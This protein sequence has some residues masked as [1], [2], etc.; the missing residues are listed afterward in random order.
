M[1]ILN[2]ILA[3]IWLILA[4]IHSLNNNDVGFIIMY[5][6]FS[7]IHLIMGMTILIKDE[8]KNLKL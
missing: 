1:K 7:I 5:Y 4:G 8:I 3:I 6:T 2:C